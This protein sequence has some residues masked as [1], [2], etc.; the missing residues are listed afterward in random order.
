MS[1]R[2]HEK[3]SNG[4]RQATGKDKQQ[5]QMGNREKQVRGKMSTSGGVYDTTTVVE[6]FWGHINNNKTKRNMELTSSSKLFY[7]LLKLVVTD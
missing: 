4:E 6:L 1:N 2:E 3:T 5:G 7:Q